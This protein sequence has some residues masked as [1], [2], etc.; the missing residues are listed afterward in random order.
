M[1]LL[2]VPLPSC[3]YPIWVTQKSS[4]AEKCPS[5]ISAPTERIMKLL[6]WMRDR[7]PF[8]IERGPGNLL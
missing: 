3:T 4:A 5:D 2:V 7:D 1:Q 6:Y 8:A